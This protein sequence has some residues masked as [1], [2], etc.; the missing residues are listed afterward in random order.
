MA[1]SK[2][3]T[4][5]EESCDLS[6]CFICFIEEFDSGERKPEFLTCYHFRA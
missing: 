5:E 4:I 1:S 3:N 6:H 2:M